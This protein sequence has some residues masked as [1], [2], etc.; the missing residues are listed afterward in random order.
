MSDIP[1]NKM[2]AARTESTLETRMRFGDH[3]I[4]T[5][6]EWITNVALPEERQPWCGNVYAGN[7]TYER[8]YSIGETCTPKL[9]YAY[10]F[11]CWIEEQ[12][13]ECNE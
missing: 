6:R 11:A 7:G 4:M 5:W 2:M 13:E 12:L 10:Y 8:M 9:V 3:G 1:L